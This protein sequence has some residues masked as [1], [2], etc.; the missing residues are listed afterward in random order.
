V[1]AETVGTGVVRKASWGLV[2]QAL[3]SLTNFALAFT[4]A[5]SL[6]PHAFGG[7][8]VAFAAYL[9]ALGFGR[10]V[11]S[12]PLVVRFSG[13]AEEEWRAGVRQAAG[14]ALAVGLIAG[15]VAVAAGANLGGPAGASLVAM[16]LFFPG[17]LLQD[18]WRFASFAA[19][20]GG[21]AAANDAIWAF[22]MGLGV[23]AL[24]WWGRASASSFALVWGASGTVAGLVGIAQ[25]RIVP[26]PSGARTWLAAHRD[27]A[28]RF[29]AQF[30]AEVGSSQAALYMIAILAGLAA[31]GGIRAAGV[32][33]GPLNVLFMGTGLFAVPEASRQARSGSIGA[34]RRT[35]LFV[36]G[37]L[38]AAVTT[39]AVVAALLPAR[40][41]EAILR[42]NWPVARSFLA[43]VALSMAASAVSA[44]AATVLR[45]LA[46]A[47]RSLRGAAFQGVLMV[48]AAGVGA[49]LGGG[50][51]AAWGLA[52]ALIV[53]SVGWWSQ[54]VRALR[55][56]RSE[57]GLRGV[58]A[59]Y[60]GWETPR[61]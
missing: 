22:T 39:W 45:G 20:R 3:S 40:L 36:S 54:C 32:L 11:A 55:D 34:V 14:T 47:P 25:T 26:R 23:I 58:G 18:T 52:A 13:A 61:T 56:A 29:A 43:P 10:S 1:R 38:V 17:L 9:L 2:D 7:F 6:D 8:S 41:G 21:T 50:R 42:E 49:T 28:W 4:A 53:A 19:G 27:L 57:A 44:G 15:A 30:F 12:E 35:G 16:G 37:G 33:L 24:A 48:A 46:D 5:R 59:P 31:V 60:I 51:G